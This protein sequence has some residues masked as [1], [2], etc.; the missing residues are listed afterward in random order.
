MVIEIYEKPELEVARLAAAPVGS[1]NHG[2]STLPVKISGHLGDR[3]IE[4]PQLPGAEGRRLVVVPFKY[5]PGEPEESMP[6]RLHDGHWGC[7]V[8]ASNDPTYKV[9]SHRLS[10]SEH[11]LVRGTLRTPDVGDAVWSP[12]EG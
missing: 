7:I 5:S 3:V 8:V 4:L 6:Y 12:T 2:L 10:I 9:G 1:T 11:E